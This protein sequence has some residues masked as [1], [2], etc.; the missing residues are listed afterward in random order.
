MNTISSKT[1]VD[2]IP[3]PIILITTLI[4]TGL[5]IVAIA[6]YGYVG[7]L[8][9]GLKNSASIQIF[10]DLIISLLFFLV[11]LK[12]DTKETKRKFIPWLIVT[13]AF[14]SFGPLLYLL[15]RKSSSQ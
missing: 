12:N 10:V 4:L 15:T 7:M 6:Q 2:A 5:T 13:L 11:W 1:F 3:K 14:G 9:E 8:K